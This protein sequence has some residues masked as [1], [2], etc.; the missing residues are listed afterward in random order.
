MVTKKVLIELE[1][2]SKDK[3]NLSHLNDLTRS[4]AFLALSLA[5]LALYAVI[6]SSL[7]LYA[8]SSGPRDLVL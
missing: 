8:I 1:K 3:A 2:I 4:K 7:R 6:R 5:C